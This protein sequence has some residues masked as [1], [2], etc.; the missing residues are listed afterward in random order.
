VDNFNSTVAVTQATNP[1]WGCVQNNYVDIAARQALAARIC[2][3]GQAGMAYSVPLSL[4]TGVGRMTQYVPIS[5]L[6]EIGLTLICGNAGEVI[7]NPTASNEDNTYTLTNISLSYDIVVPAAPYLQLLQKI[8]N[9]P[10]D[11][12]LNLPFE[13]TVCSTAASTTVS[14]GSLTEATFITSRATSNLLRSHAVFVPTALLQ[15]LQYPSQSCFSH[16]GLWAYQFRIGSLNFPMIAS[17]G[18]A[19]NY[20]T[21]QLAYGSVAQENG[22]INT[23]LWGNSTNS[24]TSSPSIFA[25]SLTTTT[26]FAGADSCIPS[27]GFQTVK[28]D[29][30]PLSMDGI[31]L[32]SASGSQQVLN[33]IFAPGAAYT[34]FI[35]MVA[36]RLLTAQ[37]GAVTVSGA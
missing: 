29:A 15:N 10:N 4:M 1:G 19:Q 14:A 5:V 6:G 13:S 23:L 21:S 17:Q 32:A 9:D 16:A 24:A 18:D 27:Y 30:I 31:S 37:G 35:S 12:G 25:D 26:R 8:A 3:N 7:Y 20:N 22:L 33:V 2:T 36:I 28:G 34:A 11:A